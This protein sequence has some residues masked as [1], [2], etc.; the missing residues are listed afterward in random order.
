[1]FRSIV[2]GKEWILKKWSFIYLIVLFEF[3]CVG[4]IENFFEVVWK[5]IVWYSLRLYWYGKFCIYICIV[6]FYEYCVRFVKIDERK[7][8]KIDNDL[9]KIV[10]WK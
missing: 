10:V 3:L 7:D 4:K 2:K 9:N 8:C 5:Y 6:W 1:M